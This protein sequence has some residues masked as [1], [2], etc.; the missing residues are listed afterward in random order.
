MYE[1][2]LQHQAIMDQEKIVFFSAI[3]VKGIRTGPS[4]LK[5]SW[6]H[7]GT[8]WRNGCPAGVSSTLDFFFDLVYV[9][10]GIRWSFPIRF[11]LYYFF[12]C[13][14]TFVYYSCGS[15]LLTLHWN[16]GRSGQA[17]RCRNV[18]F[19]VY[20]YGFVGLAVFLPIV[21]LFFAVSWLVILG[22]ILFWFDLIWTFNVYV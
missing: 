21:Y 9:P 8:W 3:A 15:L 10:I 19:D 11:V 16:E 17:V 4:S 18:A 7:R 20:C 1:T 13:T 2:F 5:N 14:R 6:S 12:K 22:N